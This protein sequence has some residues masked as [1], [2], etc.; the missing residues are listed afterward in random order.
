[1]NSLRTSV[2]LF[3]ISLMTLEF[4]SARS[5]RVDLL[6]NGSANSCSNCHF[7]ASGGGPRTPFGEAVNELVTRGGR[8]EFWTAALAAMDS[9]GDGVSNG[10]ELGDPD[11]D[12]TPVDGAEVT[13]P[14]DPNDFPALAGYRQNFDSADEGAMDL[15]D[16]SGMWSS[17]D[18]T[19]VTGGQLQLTSKD[20]GNSIGVFKSPALG[21][22]G[23][24]SYS[25]KF[26]LTLIEDAGG[27]PPAD[28]FSVNVGPIDPDP[29]ITAPGPAE[30]GYEAGLAIE[31][32]TWDNANDLEEGEFG[33]GID[34]S[35]DG[36]T[37]ENG[38]AR[39]G[40]EEDRNDSSLFKFDGI[41]R[42]VEIHWRK[43]SEAGGWA[44]G[45]VAR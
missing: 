42:T 1:M 38:A 22:D 4:A 6:P 43:A 30:E 20:T 37:A 33:I 14:G 27:N 23:A 13:L 8:E 36:V 29:E 34:V 18:V 45:C 2:A 15:G 10:V 17:T 19:F 35:V 11:G 12:G 41:A 44:C 40:A 26:D 21:I 16:G 9:D 7:R 3:L 5:F 32:D 39:I 25:V 28:G 31:F 24:E